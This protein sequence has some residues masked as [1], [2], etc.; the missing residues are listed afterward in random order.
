VAEPNY[1]QEFRR[2]PH[3]LWLA[4]LTLGLGLLSAELLGLILGV[5]AYTVGWIYLPDLPFFKRWVRKRREREERKRAMEEMV[6]F[7]RRRDAQLAKL[8]VTRSERYD[9]LAAVCR[10]IERATID[11]TDGAAETRVRKLE[12]LMWTYLRLLGMEESLEVFLESERKEDLP[13]L[14]AEAEQEVDRLTAEVDA[15]KAGGAS[16]AAETKERLLS[17]RR[18]RLEVLRRRFERS[19]E[20]KENLT[21]VVSEQDRLQQ[22][23][24]LIRADSMAMRNAE[25]LTARIDASVEQLDQT[26]KWLAQMA[27]FKDVVGDLPPPDMRI[28]FGEG[29]TVPERQKRGRVKERE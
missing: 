8:S 21:L 2:S 13:R 22:Q 6:A 10:D 5:T 9:E 25:A 23:I 17:S 15:A 29:S 26:N 27:E 18:D 7:V 14:V 12:E 16:Q 3:H 24:K 1:R 4:I 28:G 11:G 19:R 20:A